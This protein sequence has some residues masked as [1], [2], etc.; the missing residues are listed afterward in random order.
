MMIQ[1]GVPEVLEGEVPHPFECRLH[2]GRTGSHLFEQPP[3]L[4]L[5]HV[6]LSITHFDRAL[7]IT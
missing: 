3:H 5:I 4:V 6:I 7:G 1:L 2:A